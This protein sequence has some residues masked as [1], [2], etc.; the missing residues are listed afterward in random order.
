MSDMGAFM[1]EFLRGVLLCYSFELRDN[2]RDVFL[3]GHQ[4]LA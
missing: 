1:A 3:V 4:P 2:S